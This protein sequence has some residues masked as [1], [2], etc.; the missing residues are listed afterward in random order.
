MRL[1]LSIWR[2]ESPGTE[3]RFEDYEVQDASA[4]MSLLELLDR[5][6]DRLVEDGLEP[7]AFD[8][9]CREGIC[10]TCGITVDDR[11]HGPVPNTPSCRQHLRSYRDGD[12]LRLEPFRARAFPV[13]RDLV[14]DRG[15]MDRIVE[16]GGFIAVDVGTAPDADAQPIPFRTA[17]KALDFAACIQCG[18][19]VAACPNGSSHLFTGSLLEHLAT[20]P[21]G[22]PERGRRARAVA[23]AAEEEFGPCSV[24]G[25]CAEACPAGIPLSAISA[26]NREALRA[27]LRGARDD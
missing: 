22:R 6:N 9:D 18:A 8:S 26:V 15:A 1:T 11:P 16:A 13:L 10:G 25:E 14:V 2:Q 19:C 7:V 21:Q 5:L 23:Q 17:E 20:L 3:G 24:Y 27:R 4:E 12:H